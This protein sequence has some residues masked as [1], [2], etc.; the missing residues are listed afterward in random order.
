MLLKKSKGKFITAR[1]SIIITKNYDQG[2]KTYFS[3]WEIS[4][5]NYEI[6]DKS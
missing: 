2:L 1:S 6:E 5:Y 4:D 3:L